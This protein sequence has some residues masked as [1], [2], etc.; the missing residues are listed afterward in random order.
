MTMVVFILAGCEEYMDVQFDNDSA[1][2]L[3]VEGSITTDTI[4][5]TII[6]SRSGDFFEKGEQKMETGANITV[7]DGDTAFIFSETEPGIYQ[8]EP[9]VFGIA[10][11]T[12]TMNITLNNGQVYSAS[13]IIAELPEIDS[14][15]AIPNTG[16][17][18]NTG[19][20]TQGYYINYYGPEPEGL[21]DY[22]SWNLYIDGKLDSDSLQE[23]VFTDDEFVDGNYIKDFEIFFI[24]ESDLPS[25]TTEI[26][27]EMLS[28]S[29]T[30]YDYLIGLMLE[31]VWKGS[32]WDGPPANA[33]SNISNGALG[34]F[35]ASDRKTATTK[36]I[37]QP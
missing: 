25:D 28:I 7:T 10:G 1:S 29:A 6:L 20:R 16:F 13:E 15:V 5:H 11:K 22:Y 2:K 3:V 12:Y 9:T 34:Y 24:K 21:G 17:D 31:T 4:S 26:L 27:I 33:V 32:P 30:Y 18:Q 37:K 19:Q 36:I 14:V 8:S 23:K 35:R